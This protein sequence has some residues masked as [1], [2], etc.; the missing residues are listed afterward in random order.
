MRASLLALALLLLTAATA[1]GATPITYT[2]TPGLPQFE[3]AAVDP[4]PIA[5]PLP[6]QHPFM[7]PNERSNLHV[8]AYQTDANP[9][10][11]PLGH[12]PSVLSTM[13]TADCASVTFDSHGRIVT[14]CV[15]V[16]RPTLTMFDA[17]TLDTL[18]TYPLPERQPSVPGGG[19]TIF[20]DFAGGG[21]FYLD[22]QDRAIVPT[23]TRHVLVVKATDD[24]GFQLEHD[25]DLT[26]AVPSG[27]KIISALPD[28]K[29]NLWFAST[30][31]VMGTVD[32]T[33]GA[34]KSFDTGEPNGN[35]FAVDDDGGVYVVTDKA[36]YRFEA[37]ADGTPKVVWREVYDNTGEQ[38][39]GQA[40]HG[41]GTTPTVMDGGLV[42]ITDNADPM[43]VVVYRRGRQV[44][45]SRLVCKQPVFQKG[46]SASDNSLNVAG[47]SI[48]VEN[49]YGY[50]GPDAVTNGKTTSPGVERVDIDRDGQGCRRV[51][52]SD[53]VSP[54][55]VPK[56]S[57][58]A[59]L[60]YV[61][62]KPPNQ[63]GGADG[64][65][66]TGLDFRTGATRFRRLT[67]E[68]IGYNNNYAPV[69]IG[70]DGTAYVGTL[71]G[72]VAVRDATPP[73]Q[74][75]GASGGAMDDR[76]DGTKPRLAL[77]LRRLTRARVRVTVTGADRAHLRRAEFRIG[78]RR[79]AL[80]R[81]APFA[82]TL[83]LR[84]LDRR[85]AHTLRVAVRLDDGTHAT[86]K[87]AL[88]P[89]RR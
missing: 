29:G 42:S 89:K 64:C 9:L 85:R 19:G 21:Y 51:W 56:L 63:T 74:G 3:G 57:L 10:T 41:S 14:V 50:T 27:D 80:D 2:P 70:P 6:P 43:D 54:T 40:Q 45:G 18:A 37:A 66:L 15:G 30:K 36:L 84:R 53:E 79:G 47:R 87:R 59:G 4:Q 49:N 13:Q 34:V 17:T 67:G 5:A 55:V 60:M 8:D 61:Y 72:L 31:G 62:T 48:L 88:R 76:L 77:R 20:N 46:A 81:R 68:G 69:T 23:T 65:Y 16:A 25:Y 71:G 78:N 83:S 39:P 26:G 33:S 22:G 32:M 35:S 7:A 11:G 52:H 58:G 38:K 24:P 73:P 44:S 82:A 75:L 12:D 1:A 86:L 28:W